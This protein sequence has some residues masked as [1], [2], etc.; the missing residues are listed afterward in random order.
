[1]PR[2]IAC[3]DGSEYA[4]SVCDHAAWMAGRLD[5]AVEVLHVS[6]PR[7]PEDHNMV[8]DAVRRLHDE[9][10]PGATGESAPGDFPALAVRRGGDLIVMGKRGEASKRDRR[11]LGS[12]VDR[13]IRM[14]TTPVCLASKTFLPIARAI[15]LLDADMSYRAAVE[16][17]ASH[18]GLHSLEIHII[19]AAR[20]GEDP[21][22]KLQWAR[23]ALTA[24]DA[25]VFAMRADGPDD[26]AA[27]Y[28]QQRGADLIVISRAVL[29]PDPEARLGRIEEGAMWG[30]RTPVLVC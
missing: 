11:R 5:G 9:G 25:D 3:I 19:I 22:A 1:M 21:T 26:A 2:V 7:E 18:G 6:G 23:Q 20:E 15:V 12:N 27:K 10:A 30:W 29:A 28:I 4:N 16:L 13:M 8:D 14:T 17:V 24:R